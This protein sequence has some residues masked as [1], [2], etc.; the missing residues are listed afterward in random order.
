M[1]SPYQCGT[2][3]HRFLTGTLHQCIPLSR[4]ATISP[5]NNVSRMPRRSNFID[6]AATTA[7]LT[8]TSVNG[9]SEYVS[10]HLFIP[11]FQ[12]RRLPNTERHIK[13]GEETTAIGV[14]IT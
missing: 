3:L 11:L 14:D 8:T 2:D 6:P 10:L 13:N 9:S 5:H 4:P 12:N 7:F 1:L